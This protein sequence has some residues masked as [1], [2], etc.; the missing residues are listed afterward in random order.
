MKAL[1]IKNLLEDIQG[2]T[3]WIQQ[4]E[5]IAVSVVDFLIARHLIPT[6]KM[7]H[8][9]IIRLFE[10]Q[11]RTLPHLNKTRIVEKIAAELDVHPNT[12]WNTIKDYGALFA[13]RS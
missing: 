13:N 6:R 7:R 1:F 2:D 10:H 9:N 12:I 4:D 3:V 5:N 11:K 8:Y